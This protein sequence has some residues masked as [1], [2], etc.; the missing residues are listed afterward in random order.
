V[1]TFDGDDT[2][3]SLTL[4]KF[5]LKTRKTEK[6]LENINSF[7]LALNGEKMLY[8]QKEQWVIAPAEKPTGAPPK[9][10]EAERNAGL[11]QPNCRVEA[12]V[13]PGVAR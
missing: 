3:P 10:G 2:G 12:H 13:S 11:R 5:E 9:P 6:I 1:Y 7:D 4:H 8:R